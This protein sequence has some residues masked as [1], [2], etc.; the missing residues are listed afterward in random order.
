M[1]LLTNQDKSTV[2]YKKWDGSL[3]KANTIVDNAIMDNNPVVIHHVLYTLFRRNPK[4]EILFKL[5][6][7]AKERKAI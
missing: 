1:S 7:K 4:S 2:L 5:K 3:K 6:S